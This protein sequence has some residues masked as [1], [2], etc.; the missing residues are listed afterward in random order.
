MALAASYFYDYITDGLMVYTLT[1]EVLICNTN[2]YHHDIQHSWVRVIELAQ[3]TMDTNCILCHS[4]IVT[5]HFC[6]RLS[7]HEVRC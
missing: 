3:S 1:A 4:C 2:F 6:Q 7:H 5:Y